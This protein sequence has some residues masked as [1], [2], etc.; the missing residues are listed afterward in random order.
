VVLKS[1]RNHKEPTLN[2]LFFAGSLTKTRRFFTNFPRKKTHSKNCQTPDLTNIFW[3]SHRLI[4]LPKML[5]KK[6]SEKK[7]CGCSICLTIFFF[8][9][10]FFKELEKKKEMICLLT[11]DDIGISNVVGT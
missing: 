11:T 5:L 10:I 8:P 6:N 9:Q 4:F 1:K 3:F 7:H 2:L